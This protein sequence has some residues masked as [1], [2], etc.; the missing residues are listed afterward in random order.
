MSSY[1]R[2]VLSPPLGVQCAATWLMLHP[3]SPESLRSVH[4]SGSAESRRP[5]GFSASTASQASTEVAQN[6][7]N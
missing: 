1:W 6:S 2:T 4:F 7:S 5:V 3:G